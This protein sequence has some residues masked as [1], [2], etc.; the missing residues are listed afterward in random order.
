VTYL[1][2]SK[3][4]TSGS[5]LTFD[6]TNFATTGTG[7]FVSATATA[8]GLSVKGRSTDNISKI[9]FLSN[10]GA[11]EYGSVLASASEVRLNNASS[12]ALTFYTSN[13]EQMR[14]TSTGLGIG[15]SSPSYK[16]DVQT[17]TAGAL[18]SR[19][20]NSS[21]ASN[22][23]AQLQVQSDA[24]NFYIFKQS[25]TNTGSAGAGSV[26]L[27][28]DGAYP[29][30]FYT[31]STERMR[32]DSSGNLGLGVTPSAWTT[33]KPIQFAGG[34][35]LAGFS[36]TGYLNANAYFDGSWRYIATAN[37]GRYEV[38]ADHKWFSAASGTAGNAITF[39]Q[40]MT[41]DASGNLGVGTTSPAAN[42][43]I[44]VPTG[45]AKIKVGNGTVSGGSYLNLQGASGSKTWF[46]AGN[47]NIG[48]A[49]EF[50]QSTATGGSTPAGTASMLLDSSG[51]VGIGTTSPR[52]KFEV[53]GIGSF[54]DGTAA[55]PTITFG[56][57]LT[58]GLFRA[59]NATLGFSTGG[60]ERMRIDSV[61]SVGIGTTPSAWSG[62]SF[63]VLQ[64]D[65]LSLAGASG[66]SY[67]SNNW[68][69]DGSANRYI[70]TAPAQQIRMA[71]DTMIFNRAASGTAGA[72]FSWSESMRI[73]SSGQLLV[74]CT[75]APS[76]SVSGVIV[77]PALGVEISAGSATGLT[78]LMAFI[79]GNGTVGN[80]NVN[81][82]STA[83]ATSSD[84][85]LKEDIVPMAGAL[86]KVALL[87]PCTYK[88]KVDGSDGQGF[89]AHELQEVVKGCV[90]GEKDAV[91]AEGNP[92]Y[93][94]ID[95]SF[96]VATLTA[97]IQEQQALIQD[98]TTRLAALEAK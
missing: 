19:I 31:N 58:V 71:D 59:N 84:Y 15:T 27:Y 73:N 8:I 61:G 88:W 49:L 89:I 41:L 51:N 78:Y 55:A 36:N 94:G 42:L 25:S 57:E 29:M 63:K 39:T 64:N 86:A 1:N 7:T 26:N 54:G 65:R 5:A 67:F 28:A 10:D 95:T 77:K 68:Y 90:T 11:T 32:L 44:V 82:S 45:T 60:S 2:G 48:G 81:G 83:Y 62:S 50:I 37:A 47:Y 85:R 12:N 74:G 56:N 21:S 91:D 33:L 13:A 3:V 52:A 38:A 92:Q 76:S 20:Y 46:V 17:S 93:Q 34:A 70:A 18:N 40:A 96:L 69:N 23:Y 98:L 22:S 66:N 9:A 87:K 35:S 43:D 14:L 97:A 4:V 75:S 53:N 79:N 6:G 72:S 16:L 80:I 24:G 30:A